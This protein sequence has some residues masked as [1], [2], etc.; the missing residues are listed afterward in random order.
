MAPTLTSPPRIMF[1][2]D[3]SPL[4]RFRRKALEIQ[5]ST[6]TPAVE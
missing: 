2:R 3:A 4:L 1:D 6:P 5:P